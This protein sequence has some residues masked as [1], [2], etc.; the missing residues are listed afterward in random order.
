MV[1]GY[2]ELAEGRNVTD[3]TRDIDA[4]DQN[5]SLYLDIIENCADAVVVVDTGQVI[6]YVNKSTAAMFGYSGEA[7]IGKPLHIL[8]PKRVR[9]NHSTLTETFRD[10]DE[11][12]RFM[13]NRE[14][15]IQGL[16]ANGSEFPVNVSILKSGSGSNASL[17]AIIRDVTEQKELE[18]DLKRLA[19][20]DPLTGILNRRT[21]LP[22]AED[23][24]VRAKRYGRPVAFAMIDIDHFKAINDTY[25]H[26]VGDQAI[27]HVVD[28][29]SSGLRKPDIF[30]RWG[31]EEF[32]LILT[33]TDEKSALITTQRLRRSIQDTP[34]VLGAENDEQVD[35]TVSIGFGGV[36]SGEDSLDSLFE[37]VDQALYT[38]K[39]T[40]RNKVCAIGEISSEATD[41][42]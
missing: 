25:G 22:R 38:A 15:S 1:L 4:S 32:A 7:L 20:T 19:S 28:V 3:G 13:Q 30:C 9:E 34:L 23:E 21:F 39:R 10:S 27:C 29:I 17:V 8:I 5:E 24:Y 36:Q 11:P 35:M 14:V 33:E 12:S 37:R 18:E 26:A 31:G 6:T 40:G 16:R 2:R 42:A 41:A